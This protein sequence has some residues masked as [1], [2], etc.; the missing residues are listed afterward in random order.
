ML[1]RFIAHHSGVKH[2]IKN[3]ATVIFSALEWDRVVEP[4]CLKMHH[5]RMTGQSR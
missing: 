1:E 5:P 4:F 3:V 2:C